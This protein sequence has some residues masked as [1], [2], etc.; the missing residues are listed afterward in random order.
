MPDGLG[1]PAGSEEV[2]RDAVPALVEVLE[3]A[4]GSA[5][6]SRSPR[7]FPATMGVAADASIQFCRA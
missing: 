4:S 3:G 5:G 7:E 2:R 6:S 1:S